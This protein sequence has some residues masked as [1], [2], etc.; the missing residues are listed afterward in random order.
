M[1]E[2][3]NEFTSCKTEISHKIKDIFFVTNFEGNLQI[4][5]VKVISMLSL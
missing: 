4:L 1:N 2:L 5:L 3:K